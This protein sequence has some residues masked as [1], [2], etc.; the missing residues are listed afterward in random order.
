MTAVVYL[1][2]LVALSGF[3]LS[4]AAKDIDGMEKEKAKEKENGSGITDVIAKYINE[5][6]GRLE[7]V[8]KKYDSVE[9]K[10]ENSYEKLNKKILEVENNAIRCESSWTKFTNKKAKV[11]FSRAFNSPPKFMAALNRFGGNAHAG[12]GLPTTTGVNMWVLYTVAGTY[13]VTWMACGN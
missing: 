11:T 2:I 1:T 3:A 5:M 7:S 13:E 10:M 4:E 9:L 8:E 12:Y 6:N